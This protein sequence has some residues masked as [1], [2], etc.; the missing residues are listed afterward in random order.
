MHYK[1][2]STSHEETSTLRIKP[3]LG[4]FL[5]LLNDASSN[6]TRSEVQVEPAELV[7]ALQ[8]ENERIGTLETRLDSAGNLR[9]CTINVLRDQPLSAILRAAALT[10]KPEAIESRLVDDISVP[11]LL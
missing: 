10:F 8:I 2:P 5:W 6:R 11:E 3:T 4:E 7:V 1:Y 9:I